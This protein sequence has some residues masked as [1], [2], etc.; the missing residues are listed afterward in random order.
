MKNIIYDKF[1]W[2]YPEGKNCS[3]SEAKEYFSA[4]MKWLKTNNLL[5]DDGIEIFNIGIDEDFSVNSFMLTQKGNLF[6]EK[7][8]EN[9]LKSISYENIDLEKLDLMLK[10]FAKNSDC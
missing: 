8:F 3:Y 1:S 6:L 5:S 2:H 9:W 7:Y 10:E 4:L